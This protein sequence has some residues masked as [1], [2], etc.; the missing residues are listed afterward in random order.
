MAADRKASYNAPTQLAVC[1]AGTTSETGAVSGGSVGRTAT[2]LETP[3]YARS[4]EN[5][6]A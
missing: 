3:P 4:G 6:S 5:P 2:F 1:V